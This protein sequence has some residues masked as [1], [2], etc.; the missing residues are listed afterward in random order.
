[1]NHRYSAS[2]R[3]RQLEM[4][5]AK[6]RLRRRLTLGTFGLLILILLGVIWRIWSLPPY[7]AL[8]APLRGA[9]PP[10]SHIA[11]HHHANIPGWHLVW[12]DEFDRPALTARLW[13]ITNFQYPYNSQLQFYSRRYVSVRHGILHLIAMPHANHNKPFTSGMITTQHRFALHYGLI[14]IRAKL[15]TGKGLFPAIW[16]L[17]SQPHQVLP[18]IDM[19]E[20]IGRLPHHVFFS[21]HWRKANG[22]IGNEGFPY[23]GATFAKTYHT[24]TL[25]WSPTRIQW[26]VDG[27]LLYQTTNHVPQVPMYLLMNLAV[28]GYW[29]GPVSPHDKWPQSLDVQYVRIYQKNLS[30]SAA[31]VARHQLSP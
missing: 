9:L 11:R 5:W 15:P 2:D 30:S 29:P 4:R 8:P 25:N 3:L 14:V 10:V 7:P 22:L 6:R 19:M 1:M 28:G 24:Y 12:D 27:K 23:T 18:E 13:N 31:L 21:I 16:L 20:A 17:P 26:S